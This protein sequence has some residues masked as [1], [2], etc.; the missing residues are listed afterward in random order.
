MKCYYRISTAWFVFILLLSTTG[1]MPEADAQTVNIPDANL[2]RAVRQV[3][4]LNANEPIVRADIERISVL[5]ED[6]QQIRDLT[7]L[8][9]ATGLLVL[10]LAHNHISDI[11]P[12][13]GLTDLVYL[14]I[15]D[16]RISNIRPISGL[17]KMRQLYFEDNRISDISPISGL[18]DLTVLGMSLNHISDISPISGLTNLTG[19]DIASNPITDLSPLSNLVN[20]KELYV[21]IVQHEKNPGVLARIIPAETQIFFVAPNTLEFV[22]AKRDNSRPKYLHCGLG[23]SPDVYNRQR[24][25]VMIYALEFEYVPDLHGQYICTVIEIRT[26]DPEITHLDGWKLYLGTRYNPS[27]IPITLTRA[28]SQINNGMM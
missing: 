15:T 9:Y 1:G 28:N 12:I 3:L 19:S 13:S 22:K 24:P 2:A 11:R 21:D 4:Q 27:H 6:R 16:N 17:T 7:G 5:F 18:T 20:L 23:W 25:K 14:A 10:S 26:G 8:E